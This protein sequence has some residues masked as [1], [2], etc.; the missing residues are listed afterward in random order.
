MGAGGNTSLTYKGLRNAPAKSPERII[1]DKHVKDR[2][3]RVFS[4][5]KDGLEALM[6]HPRD[7]TLYTNI[8]NAHDL[9][10][11]D[12]KLDVVWK[13]RPNR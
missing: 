1:F 7:A 4:I 13:T 5:D 6:N 11:Y 2:P 8:Q 9:P 10:E 3:D 12:C